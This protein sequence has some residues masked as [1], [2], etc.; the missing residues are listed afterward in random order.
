MKDAAA[1]AYADD[2]PLFH[3]A[4]QAV[5]FALTR[6]G[7]P[8]R[9][10]SSRLLDPSRSSDFT[11][12]D[13]AGQAGMILNVVERQGRLAMAVMTAAAAPKWLNCSCRRPCCSG[14][15]KNFEWYR[16]INILAEESPIRC[17]Y[18]LRIACLMRIYGASN[19]SYRQIAEDV[20]VV[21]QTVSKHFKAIHGWLLGAKV[22]KAEPP[23]LGLEQSV[24]RAAED[25]LRAA[26]IVG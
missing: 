15:A 25:A 6:A 16:A 9:P 23:A 18:L 24:W 22:S 11:A 12:L 4:E 26:G 19:A 1:V 2:P 17:P 20:S 8:A 5:R 10:A 3:S 7:H 14:K 21:E 13:Q